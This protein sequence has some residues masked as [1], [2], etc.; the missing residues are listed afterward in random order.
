MY[1]TILTSIVSDEESAVSIIFVSMCNIS[2]FL[3]NLKI[4]LFNT[5]FSKICLYVFFISSVCWAFCGFMVFTKFV[6][7]ATTIS[8]NIF[9]SSPHLFSGITITWIL[10][11]Q[12]LPHNT[13][14]FYLFYFLIFF[15][16]FISFCIVFVLVPASSPYFLLQCLICH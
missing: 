11:C 6:K 8:S 13:L 16:L 10:G 1:S 15:S 7:F 9:P 3:A 4:S 14:M 5:G 2:F 12:I